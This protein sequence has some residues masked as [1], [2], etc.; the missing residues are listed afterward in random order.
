MWLIYFVVGIESLSLPLTPTLFFPSD[1]CTSVSHLYAGYFT[2]FSS[3]FMFQ[4]DTGD[5][6]HLRIVV[7]SGQSLAKKD[8]FGA[9]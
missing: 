3:L 6:C 5:S 7:L 4:N 1:A 9:R 8:I 2:N